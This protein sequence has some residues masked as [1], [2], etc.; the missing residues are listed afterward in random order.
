M[1]TC[2]IQSFIFL[3]WCNGNH[4]GHSGTLFSFSSSIFFNLYSKV[5]GRASRISVK[6]MALYNSIIESQKRNTILCNLVQSLSRI[7]FDLDVYLGSQ[8]FHQV[9]PLGLESPMSQSVALAVLHIQ[10]SPRQKELG[11]N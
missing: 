8:I 9:Q 6:S 7:V 4:T 1:Q 10:I 3:V 2:K 5:P 11:R